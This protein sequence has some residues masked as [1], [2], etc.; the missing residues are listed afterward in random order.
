MKS[1]KK[2]RGKSGKLGLAV[3]VALL[4]GLVVGGQVGS[5]V[6]R[7]ETVCLNEGYRVVEGLTLIRPLYFNLLGLGYFLFLAGLLFFQRKWGNG[8]AIFASLLLPP[9]FA[10]RR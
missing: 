3:I 4:A 9:T 1:G 5:I 6:W 10:A 8:E 7:G 2:G